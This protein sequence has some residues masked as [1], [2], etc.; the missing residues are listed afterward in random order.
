[1]TPIAGLC[2]TCAF[3]RVVESSRGSRF[4]LCRRSETDS[5]FPKYPA[6]PVLACGGYERASGQTPVVT[7]S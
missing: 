2:D 4:V 7:E 1:M 5:R 6:L 3:A